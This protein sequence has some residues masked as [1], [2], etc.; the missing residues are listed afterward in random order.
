MNVLFAAVGIC[1]Q[2]VAPQE[3]R[4]AGLAVSYGKHNYIYICI[5]IYHSLPQTQRPLQLPNE[6]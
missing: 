3:R 4:I 5:Y 1:L 6:I 2:V